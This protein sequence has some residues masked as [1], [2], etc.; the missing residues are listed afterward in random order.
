MLKYIERCDDM[1]KYIS[2]FNIS[3]NVPKGT[4]NQQ[5]TCSVC[6]NTLTISNKHKFTLAKINDITCNKCKAIIR[7]GDVFNF[8]TGAKLNSRLENYNQKLIDNYI[9]N[10]KYDKI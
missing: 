5:I 6:G 2:S 8:S 1:E 9:W 7:I 4:T 10:D 3:K